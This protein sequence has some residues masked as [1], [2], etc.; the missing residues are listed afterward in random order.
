MSVI[1]LFLG[2]TPDFRGQINGGLLV[3]INTFDPISLRECLYERDL[4][5]IAFGKG[6]Q[7]LDQWDLGPSYSPFMIYFVLDNGS[8][9]G[10]H[11]S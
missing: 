7:R 1:C 11:I 10:A 2:F 8:C 5:L 9:K 4:W 3:L 6:K